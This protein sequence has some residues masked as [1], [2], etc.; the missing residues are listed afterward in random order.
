MRRAAGS[1]LGL[2]VLLVAL[3][4]IPRV[5]RAQDS[6]K[7]A[8]APPGRVL[9]IGIDG[10]RFDSIEKAET[11]NLDRL[12]AAGCYSDTTQ[13]LGERYRQ[14][15]TVSG[16]GWSSLLTGVW[17]DKHGV[18]SNRFWK[19][20]FDRYP[21]FFA[22]VKEA[23]PKAST[24]SIASWPPIGDKITTAADFSRQPS[25]EGRYLPGDLETANVACEVLRGGDPAAM[26]VYFGQVDESGHQYGFSPKVKEYVAAIGLVDK[27][28][29]RILET[30]E[31]RTKYAEENWLVI[32]STDHGGFGK[33][34]GGGF[35]NPAIMNAFLIV[36]GPTTKRGKLTEQTEIVDV[37]ATALVHLGITVDPKWELDGR[38]VGLKAAGAEAKASD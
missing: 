1:H 18:D 23:Y 15:D 13:I 8:K 29:G 21:H 27:H 9:F 20:K 34:H 22:R 4:I 35:A 14:S 26:F 33:D 24:V 36:S 6:P 3:A 10:C 38:V 7:P 17:A 2:A 19:T 12:M 37:V 16:P 11:P 32:V 25:H 31:K 30:L 5:A 28:V